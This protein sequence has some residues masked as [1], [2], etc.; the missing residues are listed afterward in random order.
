VGFL[1]RRQLRLA[2]EFHTTALR[3]LHPSASPFADTRLI[4]LGS[5]RY[6]ATE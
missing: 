2:S 4:R 3:I 1:L 5:T 6:S